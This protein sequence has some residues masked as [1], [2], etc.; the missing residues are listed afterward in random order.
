MQIETA[1]SGERAIEMVRE[2]RY[3]VIFMDYMMPYM[4]G[5]ETTEKIRAEALKHGDN[6][7]LNAYFKSVPIIALSG[8]DSEEAKEKF[9]RAGIDDFTVKPIELKRLKKLLLKWLPEELIVPE[10]AK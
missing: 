1:T 7:E 4:D 3:H 6:Y 8:D 5:V 10:E 2:N 9:L